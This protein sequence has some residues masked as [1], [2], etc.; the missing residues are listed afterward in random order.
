[1]L[2]KQ[3]YDFYI[4]WLHIHVYQKAWHTFPWR[5]FQGIGRSAQKI[6][7]PNASAR[8]RRLLVERD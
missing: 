8:S 5:K 6:S 2:L 7:S 3:A 1:L 4:S